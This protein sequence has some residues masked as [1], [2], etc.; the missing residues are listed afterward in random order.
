ME[1]PHV[2]SSK[3]AQNDFFGLVTL[4]GIYIQIIAPF[5]G[6]ILMKI[7]GSVSIGRV[8]GRRRFTL[9]GHSASICDKP[10]LTVFRRGELLLFT[11]PFSFLWMI[12]MTFFVLAVSTQATSTNYEHATRCK[13]LVW[14]S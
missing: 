5:V 13:S 7:K 11:L 8:I 14:V 2:G 1:G 9:N 3:G 6:S 12:M 10:E 4:V